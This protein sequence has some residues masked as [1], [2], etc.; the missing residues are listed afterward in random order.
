MK[1]ILVL[2]FLTGVFWATALPGVGTVNAKKYKTQVT[3]LTTADLAQGPSPSSDCTNHRALIP[4]QAP[5]PMARQAA[6]LS[7]R[8][9]PLKFLRQKGAGSAPPKKNGYGTEQWYQ[10]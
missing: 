1:C 7:S 4:W 3:G 10:D 9:R 8:D 6:K 5:M 2:L